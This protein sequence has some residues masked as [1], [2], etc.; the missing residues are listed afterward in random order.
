MVLDEFHVPHACFSSFSNSSP[1]INA[2]EWL[3]PQRGKQLEKGYVAS[4][5]RHFS[6]I[7]KDSYDGM[8]RSHGHGQA[9]SIDPELEFCAVRVGMCG[10]LHENIQ[11]CSDGTVVPEEK[12]ISV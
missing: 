6:Y 10:M 1:W 9:H 11:G 3:W 7:K 4:H 2:S 5:K 12:E 8:C